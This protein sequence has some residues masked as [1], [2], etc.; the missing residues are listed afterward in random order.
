MLKQGKCRVSPLAWSKLTEIM[1]SVLTEDPHD[2]G[3]CLLCLDASERFFLDG[4]DNIFLTEQLKALELW[5]DLRLW[6]FIFS[7]LLNSIHFL[8]CFF[9]DSWKN[10]SFTSV[11]KKSIFKR[12]CIEMEQTYRK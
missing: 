1:V 11:F 2:Y 4:A 6:Q 9:M 8:R 12:R 5:K 7:G 10:S 3:V